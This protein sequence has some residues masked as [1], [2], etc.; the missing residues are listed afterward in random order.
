MEME[1]N[2]TNSRNRY[3][4]CFRGKGGRTDRVRFAHQEHSRRCLANLLIII[5]ATLALLCPPWRITPASGESP[6]LPLP[7]RGRIAN[8]FIVTQLPPTPKTTVRA[9]R[10]PPLRAGNF[11][12]GARLVKV[13]PDFSTEVLSRSFHSACDPEISFD[14]SHI[15]FAGKRTATDNWTIFEMAIDGSSIRQVTNGLSNCR[16]P[17]YQATM[18]TEPRQSP[19]CI[20]V[21]STARLYAA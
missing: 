5:L 10:E 7:S 14:A 3:F 4:P 2:K 6:K 11:G 8:A 20:P 9:V 1:N 19:T 15:L 18:N 16:S 12:D 13:Y 21:S 17:G